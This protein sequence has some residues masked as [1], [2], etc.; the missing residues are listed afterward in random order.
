MRRQRHQTG[1]KGFT[2]IEMV[3]VLFILAVLAG[4]IVSIVAM[5]RR[6]AEMA[7]SAKNQAD[8]ANQ[9]QLYFALQSRYPQGLDSLLLA[10]G[11][12]YVPEGVVGSTQT[13]GMSISTVDGMPA[14]HAQLTEGTLDNSSGQY[15]RSFSRSGFEYVFDHVAGSPNANRSATV[16]RPGTGSLG[17]TIQ[18]A[19]VASGQPIIGRLVP[20]GDGAGTP[21]T[22]PA[23]TRLIAL[24]FGERNATLGKTGQNA[25]I[26]PGADGTYYGRFICYF[27]VY[28]SGERATLAGVSDCMGRVP[29]YTIG[30]FTESLP[31]GG[32]QP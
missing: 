31:N 25:P 10:G 27:L 2:L 13:G 7:G 32:R 24:G 1:R 20:L 22:L 26:F 15:A 16:R 3:V 23:G 19:E 9:I 21:N 4:L 5:L 8:I 6:S 17:S 28:A 14:L 30:Q 29:D 11:G 18:V 12:I